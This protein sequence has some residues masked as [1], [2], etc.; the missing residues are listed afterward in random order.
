MA[1]PRA[2]ASA[3]APRVVVHPKRPE[4]GSGLIV[5]HQE[6]LVR[7]RFADGVERSFRGDVLDAVVGA[8]DLAAALDALKVAQP[9][10][11]AKPAK[12]VK[13][14]RPAVKPP[15]VKR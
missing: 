6:G 12:P 13:A 3:P 2:H 5:F 7:V 4:W 9:A 15:R 11:L 14:A 1:R 10:K 8:E